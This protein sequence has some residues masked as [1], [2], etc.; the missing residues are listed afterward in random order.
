MSLELIASKREKRASK[1]KSRERRSVEIRVTVEKRC[2][3]EGEEGEGDEERDSQAPIR[4]KLPPAKARLKSPI[5][6]SCW[7][8][9][10]V[11][12]IGLICCSVRKKETRRFDRGKVRGEERGR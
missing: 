6:F 11:G 5:V 10:C 12:R 8:F 9:F 1:M 2:A 4:M 7:F 3:L